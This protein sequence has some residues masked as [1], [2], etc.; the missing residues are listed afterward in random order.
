[1]TDPEDNVIA[2]ANEPENNT[3]S[4]E[5]G[6]PKKEYILNDIKRETFRNEGR[7]FHLEAETVDNFSKVVRQHYSV[8]REVPAGTLEPWQ[9]QFQKVFQARVEATTG[10]PIGSLTETEL[11]Q[12]IEAESVAFVSE[13]AN[14]ETAVAITEFN[15]TA[16]E[17]GLQVNVRNLRTLNT[18]IDVEIPE[19]IS[20]GADVDR[21][22][23]STPIG[24][25]TGTVVRRIIG[26]KAITLPER[27]NELI[28]RYP[29]G[30]RPA[31][32]AHLTPSE[33]A[34]YIAEVQTRQVK[35]VTNKTTDFRV[36]FPATAAAYTVN[37]APLTPAQRIFIESYGLHDGENYNS[38]ST[39]DPL[40]PNETINLTT[41]MRQTIKALTKSRL[42]FYTATGMEIARV[43]MNFN[44]LTEIQAPH[45]DIQ[46][47][48]YDTLS[49]L[50]A[51]NAED[52]RLEYASQ[53]VS[54]AERE[55]TRMLR[56]DEMRKKESRERSILEAQRDSLSTVDAAASEAERKRIGDLIKQEQENLAKAQ[57]REAAEATIVANEARVKEIEDGFPAGSTEIADYE[58]WLRASA[59]A[60]VR[61]ANVA[62][63]KAL[64]EPSLRRLKELEADRLKFLPSTPNNQGSGRGGAPRVPPAP[65]PVDPLTIETYNDIKKQIND[66]RA[67]F[68]DHR[69][70][71]ITLAQVETLLGRIDSQVLS[72]TQF[73]SL[74]E[75]WTE[76]NAPGVKGLL[77]E[78]RRLVA[79]VTRQRNT[80]RAGIGSTYVREASSDIQEKI[81]TL[82]EQLTQEDKPETFQTRRKQAIETYL[83]QVATPE[84]MVALEN[85]LRLLGLPGGLDFPHHNFYDNYP[86][87][88]IR[89]LQAAFGDEV[90]GENALAFDQFSRLITP[91]KFTRIYNTLHPGSIT[92]DASFRALAV[93]S[94][95]RAVVDA[96]MA[97]LKQ[98]AVVDLSLGAVPL[99]EQRR[100]RSISAVTP[101]TARLS[102][103]EIAQVKSLEQQIFYY[104][105]DADLRRRLLILTATSAVPPQTP[106]AFFGSRARIKKA[107]AF[108]REIDIIRKQRRTQAFGATT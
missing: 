18:S 16:L 87:V 26:N 88:Y 54:K 56:E 93:G 35:N 104:E 11:R 61:I 81:A 107:A 8:F 84:A 72:D 108:A 66:L 17:R 49:A 75:Q 28:D 55:T 32:I 7:P 51:F 6:P 74:P 5:A 60:R 15:L 73:L 91:E 3:P 2:A 31:I 64:Y 100:M 30:V 9:A 62:I 63:Q 34:K 57:A 86:R 101:D 96:I 48:A 90:V 106:Y 40:N 98:E 79:Q 50:G 105:D 68:R 46:H 10:K 95:D 70:R 82:T 14:L 21:Y 69:G 77:D 23:A 24:T 1:M 103:A 99:V 36:D 27:I 94:V 41:E 92:D 20:A 12:A 19:T 33:Q 44:D 97:Q 42:D 78:R 89:A 29:G 38:N 22:R 52:L 67:S 53:A 83:Q 59:T 39:I 47:S 65:N 25:L 80:I 102:P 58:A 37:M 45:T 76:T 71:T 13:A 43:K 4:V 85:R